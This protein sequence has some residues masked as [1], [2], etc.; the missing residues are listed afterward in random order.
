MASGTQRSRI[1][2]AIGATALL[3][4]TAWPG[5]PRA[6]AQSC[7]LELVLA[8]DISASVNMREYGLQISG[9]ARAFRDRAVIDAIEATAPR[10]IAVSLVQWSGVDEQE[11]S[12]AWT[13]LRDALSA[14]AFAAAIE[15]LSRPYNGIASE[16]GI[17]TGTAL[18]PALRF[19]AAQLET[20][21]MHCDRRVIDVSGD[22]RANVGEPIAAPRASIIARGITINGLAILSDEGDLDAYYRDHVI[23]G[24]AAF[25]M[26]A[27]SHETFAIAIRNKLLREI[28]PKLASR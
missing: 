1:A 17:G 28:A 2:L 3:A 26:T 13:R 12:V 22:G 9:F 25:V 23:G 14:Q 10:G 19:A 21:G 15:A 4:L 5:A 18:G 8:V 24:P 7:A 11:R 16:G 20:N 6:D 27:S